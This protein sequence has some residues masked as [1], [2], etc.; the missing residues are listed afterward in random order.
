MSWTCKIGIGLGL[1]ILYLTGVAIAE[2][3]YVTDELRLGVREGPGANTEIIDV[4]QSGQ[5]M[6]LLAVEGQWARVRLE[7]GREGWV[8]ERYLTQGIT[9]NLKL[10][11]LQNRYDSL[12]DQAENLREENRQLNRELGELRAELQT[13]ARTA[14]ESAE[15]Y[16]QLKTGASEYL[17]L[18]SAYENAAARLAEQ[19]VRLQELNARVD[20]LKSQRIIRWL[21]TGAGVVLLGFIIGVSARRKKRSS[22]LS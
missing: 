6:A 16:E 1:G 3:V 13:A 8:L 17:Q 19:D 22:L 11:R 14:A 15:A 10:D 20:S 7:D 9:A 2:T 18:K 5:A 21:L 12:R 4:A